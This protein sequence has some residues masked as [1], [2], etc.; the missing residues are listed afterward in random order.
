MNPFAL[1]TFFVLIFTIFLTSSGDEISFGF[2]DEESVTV[3]K[4]GLELVPQKHV[5][6]EF[7]AWLGRTG[8]SFPGMG[9]EIPSPQMF[10]IGL[11]Q[12][13]AQAF[14]QSER[15]QNG[16]S[17]GAGSTKAEESIRRCLWSEY[18][19]CV[20]YV[21]K[22]F[23]KTFAHHHLEGASTEARVR[24]QL[25]SVTPCATFEGVPSAIQFAN[26]VAASA[27]VVFKGAIK[28]WSAVEVNF[29]GVTWSYFSL[30]KVNSILFS[31][32]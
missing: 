16:R 15:E 11:A 32:P 4:N 29:S 31:P 14:C 3:Q 10:E 12:S 13:L 2:T 30:S 5:E 28:R 22:P 18:Q 25:P 26:L 27:P 21:L 17:S 9:E 7:E 20:S 1:R 23:D 8:K 19:T 6:R 24:A